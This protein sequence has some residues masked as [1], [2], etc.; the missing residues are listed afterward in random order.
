MKN[1]KFI[2][3]YTLLIVSVY[4]YFYSSIAIPTYK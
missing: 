2:I 3:I 4:I 1:S